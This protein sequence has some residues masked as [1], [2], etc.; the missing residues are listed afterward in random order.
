MKHPIELKKKNNNNDERIK[1]QKKTKEQ[2]QSYRNVLAWVYDDA[3][4]GD[5]WSRKRNNSDDILAN[6][7]M[8]INE[9]SR[10][11]KDE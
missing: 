10:K 2:W 5:E 9:L 8:S 7:Y 3:D 1:R 4:D 6:E 11:M